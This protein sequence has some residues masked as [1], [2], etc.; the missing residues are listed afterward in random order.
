M[1]A[2]FLLAEAINIIRDELKLKTKYN[3]SLVTQLDTRSNGKSWVTR[4]LALDTLIN[5]IECN[6]RQ[7]EKMN[8]L[9]EVVCKEYG[10]CNPDEITQE[11]LTIIQLLKNKPKLKEQLLTKL[12]VKDTEN[13]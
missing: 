10:L 13:E 8:N 12:K 7:I 4:E 11:E 2:D 1:K 9:L 5:I 3:E 6:F